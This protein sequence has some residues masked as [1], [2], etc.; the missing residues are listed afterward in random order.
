VELQQK[1][2]TI[3]TDIVNSFIDK[4]HIDFGREYIPDYVLSK[5]FEYE[6]EAIIDLLYGTILYALRPS[7]EKIDI[8]NIIDE[9]VFSFHKIFRQIGLD[10]PAVNKITGKKLRVDMLIWHVLQSKE[11]TFFNHMESFLKK[12][13]ASYEQVS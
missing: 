12:K 1:S 6:R 11:Q 8:N 9:I 2:K 13:L 3:A 10:E 5:L 7:E 4:N